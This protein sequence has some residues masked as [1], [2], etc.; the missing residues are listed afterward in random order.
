[1]LRV[2][3]GVGILHLIDELGVGIIF[4]FGRFGGVIV[5]VTIKVI[6]TGTFDLLNLDSGQKLV[7]LLV[8]GVVEVA[9]VGYGAKARRSSSRGDWHGGRGSTLEIPLST[10]IMR[11]SRW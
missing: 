10:I 11:Q 3:V 7:I 2:F 4:V 9:Q 1:M 6:N 8:H 5:T